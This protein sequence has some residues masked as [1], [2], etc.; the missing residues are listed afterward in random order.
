MQ[1][2]EESPDRLRNSYE[3]RLRKLR[4]FSLEKRWL[5]HDLIVAFLVPEGSIQERWRH[6]FYKGV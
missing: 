1:A 4:L 2:G 5:K 6:T 3:E